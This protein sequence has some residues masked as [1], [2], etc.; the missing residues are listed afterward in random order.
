MSKHSVSRA[1]FRFYPTDGL[2]LAISGA[3]IWWWWDSLRELSLMITIVVGHLFVFCNVV[4]IRRWFE[5]VWAGLF[6][7]AILLWIAL[8]LIPGWLVV[9]SSTALASVLI[10][11]EVRSPRYHGMLSRRINSNLDKYLQDFNRKKRA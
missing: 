7:V 8:R 9:L 1:G 6:C 4:R 11:I 10:V 5:L 2:V 3:C